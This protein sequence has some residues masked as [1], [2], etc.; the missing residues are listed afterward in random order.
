M[1]LVVDFA[2]QDLGRKPRLLVAD[3]E[4]ARLIQRVA[5]AFQ[6]AV[7]V[8]L[9]IEHVARA[10]FRQPAG[11]F[12]QGQDFVQQRDA[13][14][15]LAE[16]AVQGLAAPDRHALP[17]DGFRRRRRDGLLHLFRNGG[18]RADGNRQFVDFGRHGGRFFTASLEQADQYSGHRQRHAEH[19]QLTAGQPV[20]VVLDPVLDSVDEARG[21]HSGLGQ[22]IPWRVQA[23]LPYWRT[24]RGSIAR[25]TPGSF[26]GRFRKAS[27]FKFAPGE[28]DH[29]D[30]HDVFYPGNM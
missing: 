29:L 14:A 10:D 6:G 20:L 24:R 13:E 12:A 9:E 11:V 16:N 17:G 2:L 5:H 22:C 23:R 4:V 28:F 25:D 26:R 21:F 8:A 7:V 27:S 30:S 18:R 15:L 19:G 3:E 1:L